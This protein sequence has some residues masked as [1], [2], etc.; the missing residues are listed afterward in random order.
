[1]S[2]RFAFITQE[3]PFY[4][5]I[6][7]DEFL[8]RWPRLEEIGAVF[9][10]PSMGKRSVAQLARQMYEFYGP[11]DFVRL[12]ARYVI[13]KLAARLP[14]GRGAKRYYSITQACKAYGVPVE[15]IPDVN[16]PEFIARL[17]AMKPELVVS[18]A[19]PQI[20]R[21]ALLSVPR[22]GCINIHNSKL[23]KYRGMLPNFWQLYNGERSVGTS[24]H[25]I[26]KSL[27]DGAILLQRETPITPGETL[28]S[29]ILRTKR[30][31]AEI[32]VEAVERLL[33][34]SL[35]DLPNERAESSYYSFPTKQHVTEFRR[36]GLRLI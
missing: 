26:N 5:R 28:E 32:M 9:I 24:I 18:V 13:Y 30:Q 12:G 4:V 7:F 21:E 8:K 6:F 34:G 31:G 29:L 27:D 15:H 25:R 23:P 20:F 1:M 36:R 14:L 11:A 19:A 17:R 22:L 35:D 33:S 2:R 10:A 3:D 16:A